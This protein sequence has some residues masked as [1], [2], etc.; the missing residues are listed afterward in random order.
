M[1]QR[2]EKTEV[3]KHFKDKKLSNKF[4][5]QSHSKLDSESHT[6]FSESL[7]KFRVNQV[8]H[9]RFLL[10]SFFIATVVRIIVSS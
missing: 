6:K 5:S 9:D 8:Q 7:N 2:K 4:K 1:D 3:S 10:D